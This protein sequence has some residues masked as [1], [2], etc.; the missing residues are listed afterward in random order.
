[1]KILTGKYKGWHLKEVPSFFLQYLIDS[2]KDETLT[3][4][5]R[6]EYDKRTVNQSHQ[7]ARREE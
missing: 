1:M 7:K 3:D 6:Q 2:G 4:A 5:A